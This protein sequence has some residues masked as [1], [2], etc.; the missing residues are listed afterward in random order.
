MPGPLEW[1]DCASQSCRKGW[2]AHTGCREPSNYLDNVCLVEEASPARCTRR[3][4][5]LCLES[6]LSLEPLS[7]LSSPLGF[8]LWVVYTPQLPSWAQGLV[9]PDKL[10][11]PQP[12]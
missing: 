5:H 12:A 6:S 3:G 1:A 8:Q 4:Q 10:L 11:A 2:P 7:S 9:L